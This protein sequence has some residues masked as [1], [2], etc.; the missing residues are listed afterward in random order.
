MPANDS[1]WQCR[2]TVPP[3]ARRVAAGEAR[4][5]GELERQGATAM[6]SRV[7]LAHVEA[8]GLEP[9]GVARPGGTAAPRN[10]PAAR[11][12]LPERH[13]RVGARG[14]PQGNRAI[15]HAR[16]TLCRAPGPTAAARPTTLCGAPAPG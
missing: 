13:P 10:I 9:G 12:L 7:V 1:Q 6:L 4:L 5:V 15:W 11:F 2:M 16:P 8:R 14:A 3:W